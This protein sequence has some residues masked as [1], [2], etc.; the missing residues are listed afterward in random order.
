MKHLATRSQRA[1]PI[2]DNY[3]AAGAA[4]E[5]GDSHTLLDVNALITRG[6]DGYIAFEVTG[7]S[8]LDHIHPGNIIFVDTWAE[9]NNGDVIAATVNGL[10]CVKIFQR[11]TRGLYLVSANT[12]YKPRE[13]TAHDAFAVL[14][15]V[16]GHLALYP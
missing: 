13:I 7:D 15:V 8:M 5:I 1:I 3:I 2:A 14:G 6:R 10:T 4:V 16:R 9:A 12:E 11:S